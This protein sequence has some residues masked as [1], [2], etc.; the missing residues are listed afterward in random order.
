[1]SLNVWSHRGALLALLLGTGRSQAFRLLP[2]TGVR[3][4]LSETRE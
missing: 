2:C 1:M 3:P 4:E